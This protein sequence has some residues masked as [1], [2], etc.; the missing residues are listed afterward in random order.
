M[1][2]PPDGVV[3]SAHVGLVVGRQKELKL[4]P[5]VKPLGNRHALYVI[6][7]DRQRML[8]ASSP[9]GIT[10]L[11]PLPEASEEEACAAVAR[12]AFAD[13]LQRALGRRG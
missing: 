13:S 8:V 5:E 4:W 7:Y 2:A 12:P 1:H 9:A 3:G 11:G 10:L 6:G